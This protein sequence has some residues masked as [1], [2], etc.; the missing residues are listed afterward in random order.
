MGGK[1]EGTFMNVVKED[2]HRVGATEEDANG[3]VRRQI[4][5]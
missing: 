2:L 3:G 4:I 1:E 5:C